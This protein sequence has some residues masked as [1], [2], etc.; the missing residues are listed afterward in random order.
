VCVCVCVWLHP[1]VP[2]EEGVMSGV[3]HS[4]GFRR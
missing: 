2:V 4:V 1:I 3:Y